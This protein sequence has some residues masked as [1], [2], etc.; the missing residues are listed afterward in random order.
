MCSECVCVC[1]HPF[2]YERVRQT[3][4]RENDRWEETE[5][6]KG[7]TGRADF[8]WQAA[9]SEVVRLPGPNPSPSP[10]PWK[11]VQSG[12]LKE[13][14]HISLLILKRTPSLFPSSKWQLSVTE[15]SWQQLIII[16]VSVKW[17]TEKM[18]KRSSPASCVCSGLGLLWRLV[19][20][21]NVSFWGAALT[22]V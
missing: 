2:K 6:D 10:R 13:K 12:S 15:V 17:V 16:L 9:Q 8:Y 20:H 21:G 19:K 7:R 11:P 1:V 14:R 3:R 18:G 22:T 4:Q 5:R